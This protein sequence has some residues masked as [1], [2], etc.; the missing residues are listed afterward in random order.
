VPLDLPF[1]SSAAQRRGSRQRELTAVGLLM[2]R[3]GDAFEGG[4]R[5]AALE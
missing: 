1:M 3:C 4:S 5:Y 2:I